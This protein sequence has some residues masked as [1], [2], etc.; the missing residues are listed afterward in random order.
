MLMSFCVGQCS[1]PDQ[2]LLDVLMLPE[3]Y[4]HKQMLLASVQHC[5][6]QPCTASAVH[7]IC[8]ASSTFSS[9]AA[10]EIFTCCNVV[11]VDNKL[12]APS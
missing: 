4:M 2:T 8:C 1:D 3:L 7:D 12:T 6:G 5:K 10:I 9:H 11:K